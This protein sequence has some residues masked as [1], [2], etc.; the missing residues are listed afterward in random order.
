M[1]CFGRELKKFL[2]LIPIPQKG[3]SSKIPKMPRWDYKYIKVVSLWGFLEFFVV[4]FE[5]SMFS[6]YCFNHSSQC[7][8][9]GVT[10]TVI[11]VIPSVG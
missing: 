3:I 2:I 9:T 11:C 1:L 5:I 8:T 7:S 10:N 6:I 4:V